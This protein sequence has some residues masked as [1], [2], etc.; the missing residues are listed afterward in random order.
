VLCTRPGGSKASQLALK[1]ALPTTGLSDHSH[2]RDQDA[3]A[4]ESQGACS[5]S[6]AREW[7]VN[8][9]YLVAS[10]IRTVSPLREPELLR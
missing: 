2:F 4:Q 9:C 8:V 5:V 7:V 1:I 3:E 6:M 10:G